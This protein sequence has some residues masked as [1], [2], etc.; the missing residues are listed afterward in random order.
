[1]FKRI[2]LACLAVLLA[3]T[4]M[5]GRAV[6]FEVGFGGIGIRLPDQIL[7]GRH[8]VAPRHRTHEHKDSSGDQSK[9]GSDDRNSGSK[10]A[11]SKLDAGS[12]PDAGSQWG[13]TTTSAG[14]SADYTARAQDQGAPAIFPQLAHSAVVTSVAFSPDSKI[15]ASGSLDQ[16]INLWDA[17]S[18]RELRTLT[19]GSDVHA[20]AYSPDGTLLASA[21]GAVFVGT[22]A[23]RAKEFVSTE[24][25][26]KIWNA[27][28]GRELRTLSG[29]TDIVAA[30]AFSP[31]GKMLAS[32][33]GD[34]TVK[35]WDVASGRE[36]R[37][38]SGHTDVV[39]AVAFSPDGKTLASGSFDNTIKLW[40]VASGRELGTLA[41]HDKGVKAIAFSPN[42]HLLASGGGEGAI[43]LWDLAR[44]QVHTLTGHSDEITSLAFSPDGRTLASGSI[45]KTIKLWNVANG[46]NLNTLTGYLKPVFTV[47]FSPDGKMF[48][49]GSADDTIELWD[50]ASS[51]PL[52]N[53]GRRTWNVTPIAVSPDGKLLVSGNSH[54]MIEIWDAA[55]GQELRTLSGHVLGGDYY[56]IHSLA[57]SPDGKMLA[58]GRDDGTVKLWD[59]AAGRELAT[60]SGH[61]RS[62]FSV[63]FSPDG[64]ILAAGN[65]NSTIKL[66]D[67]ASGR[68]LRTLRG[69]TAEVGSVAFSPDGKV[70]ASAGYDE[71]IRLW[72]VASG[73][74]LRTLSGGHTG[75]IAAVAFSP[76]G[77]VLASGSQDHA[78][79]L[80]DVA[81]GRELR[82]LTGHSQSVLTVA[83]SPD[84]KMLASGSYDSTIKLWDVASWRELRTLS[85]NTLAIVRSITFSPDGRML[86]STNDD[87]T[88]RE[89]DVASG[90]Q[91]VAL[92]SFY[93]GTDYSHLA[94]T[95]EGFFDSSSAQAEEYLNVRVGNRVFGIGAYREKFYRP[96]LVKLSLAGG[97]LTR[98]GSIGGEKLPPMVELVDLPQTTTDPKLNVT[99]RL[100]DGGGGIGLVR[101]FLNG[102]AVIQDDKPGALTRSYAVP[103]LNGPNELRAVAFNA[104]GSVQSNSATASIAAHLPQ[105]PRGTLHALIVGIQEFP[106]RP[107]N[108]LTYSIADAQLFADTLKKYSAPLFEKL[109]IKL[110]TTAAETDKDHV[111][112]AL[113]AMQATAG[114]DDEFVFY[115]A[116]HG[117]V[118]DGEYYLITSNVSSAA[119]IK[120]EAISR[121]Q[122][123]GLLANIHAAKKL[124]IIDT[125]HA[126]PVGDALQQ[127]IQSG[128][129]TDSTATTILSRQIGSTV[130]AAATTDQ[131]A[132]EGYK[133][134]GLFTRVIA[135]GLGGQAAMK[136]IVSN[137]SLADYVGAEV[138]PLASNLYQHEQTPTVS[139]TGQRFP[140]AEVK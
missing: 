106:K 7:R 108:N 98:F 48:A 131:E 40:D 120:T 68:E 77:K 73:R 79:E 137:F 54:D 110:L 101:V 52:R 121:Q 10:E 62:V 93:D 138:P 140:I 13:D 38:L 9:D 43:K 122:L 67:V 45:D 109:D 60:L 126:E 34:A 125:C 103:L 90:R 96:D 6:A 23:V 25:V 82:T 31:D 130:L 22:E 17:A 29:H 58:S 112:Q 84:G 100:S 87:G 37:T 92:I 20:I 118:V 14:H 102:S 11:G 136:G 86:A 88:V 49:S 32:G 21:S 105:A 16:T 30:V 36:L 133:D 53:L 115:V 72:D 56:K 64:K 94:I 46:R 85:A 39:V 50:V 5:S 61:T 124:V 71:T 119:T 47:A 78:I 44:R 113:T 65:Y 91:R 57:F 116:S 59:A 74:E 123:A 4:L 28:D 81:S 41:G 66:W 70:L 33:S 3:A 27:S 76:D 107:Q 26:I 55:S 8:G 132:L 69:H 97:S 51:N 2:S 89:W 1:M 12:K 128:G 24:N 42:G 129:M 114:P 80:W 111:V 139:A 63:A 134:H 75:W 117:L 99:L 127:A 19:C 15:L 18:G 104:D 35:L 135:D 95:P 83:F